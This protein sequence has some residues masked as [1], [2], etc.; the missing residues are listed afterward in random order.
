MMQALKAIRLSSIS[1][2]RDGGASEGTGIIP[3]DPDESTLIVEPHVKELG[4]EEESEY[5]KEE[6]VDEEMDWVYSDEYEEYVQEN[7]DEE[8][9]DAKV[10]DIGNGDEEITNTEKADHEKTEKVKE[11]NKKAKLPYGDQLRSF[12]DPNLIDLSILLKLSH[13]G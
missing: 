8:M 2:P 7:V 12:V 4:S 3:G 11:D 6:N 1:Q 9:K 10:D 5:F 13:L